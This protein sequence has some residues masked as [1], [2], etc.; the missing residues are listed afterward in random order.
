MTQPKTALVRGVDTARVNLTVLTAAL[1][2]AGLKFTAKTSLEERVALLADYELE[3]HAD[4]PKLPEDQRKLVECDQC[5]GMSSVDR[6]CCPFCGTGEDKPS[7]D[8]PVAD[9]PPRSAKEAKA[10]KAQAPEEEESKPEAKEKPRK[11]R[12]EVAKEKAEK[13]AKDKPEPKE[14]P[15]KEKAE[16]KATSGKL[17]KAQI[18]ELDVIERRIKGLYQDGMSNLWQVGKSLCEAMEKGLWKRRL[19]SEG[20]PVHATFAAWVSSTFGIKTHHARALMAVSKSFTE[21]QVRDVGVTKLDLILKLPPGAAREEMVARAG[22]FTSRELDSEVRRLGGSGKERVEVGEEGAT[23]NNP[24]TQR[25]A[26]IEANRKRAGE[27]RALRSVGENEVTAVIQ[28][29]QY[30]L[31]LFARA[32]SAE[33]SELVRAKTVAADPHAALDLQNGI[34]LYIKIVEDDE[35]LVA[36]LEYRRVDGDAESSE[37]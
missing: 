5:F 6:P 2:E 10:K 30:T 37:E 31:P 23:R 27:R 21:K 7:E 25:Q 16:V 34:R 9:P 17:T 13:P 36:L 29:Q 19:D 22:E 14:E 35:G 8:S 11:T 33:T 18:G 26:V 24:L 1:K 20:S 3:Q 12:S 15:A 32:K 28:L 4:D